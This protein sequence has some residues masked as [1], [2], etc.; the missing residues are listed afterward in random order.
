MSPRDDRA[1]FSALL[2]PELPR[3]YRLA[4]RLTGTR[5]DAEDL[6]QDVLLKAWPMLDELEALD[7]PGPWLARVLYHRFV[8]ERRRFARRR[9]RIVDEAELPAQRIDALADSGD[10]L[11]DYVRREQL[12]LLEQAIESLAESQRLVLLMHDVEGYTLPEIHSITGE[13]LG[14]LKSRLHRARRRLR[15]LL[16]ELAGD[17]TIS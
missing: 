7:Q 13:A 16:P 6:L 4:L 12:A 5:V 10:D 3:L 11:H 17:G 14:T 8:D 9:L 1:R 2:E 15:E